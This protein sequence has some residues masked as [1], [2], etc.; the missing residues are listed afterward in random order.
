MPDS[1]DTLLA[2]LN[3]LRKSPITLSKTHS[4]DLPSTPQRTTDSDLTA[5]FRSLTPNSTIT[6]PLPDAEDTQHN[7]E[8]DR[9]IEELLQDLG[10]EEQWSVDRD[11][12]E[13]IRDLMAEAKSA[14]PA[15][16]NKEEENKDVDL[17]VGVARPEHDDE[18]EEQKEMDEDKRDEE[19]ADDYVQRV[20]AELTL[21]KK[22]GGPEEEE[23]EQDD[24]KRAN[25]DNELSLPSAPTELPSSPAPDQ[26]ANIDDA[27]SARFA[28]LS[29]PGVPSF[30]PAKKP[31]N[32]QKSVKSNLPKYT[33]EDMESWCCICNEDATVKCIGCDGDLYCQECWREGH[34]NGPGQERDFR[35]LDDCLGFAYHWHVDHFAIQCP[36]ASTLGISLFVGNDDSYGIIHLFLA[37]AENVLNQ[38]DLA[39]MDALLS[40]VTHSL[41]T[42]TFFLEDL[43]T[44][45]TAECS[46]DQIDGGRKVEGSSCRRDGRPRIQEFF[47]VRRTRDAKIEGKVLSS[48]DEATQ[49]RRSFANGRQVHD[50]SRR[51]NQGY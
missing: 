15:E 37:W 24:E 36:S 9:T 44:L 32:I 2:R 33:D 51:L 20:L 43:L 26:D 6:S 38:L 48:E 17:E 4:L 14:L 30:N 10:P 8:D 34:G 25:V 12:G 49:I 35:L 42:L 40:I 11:E 50:C 46:R 22:Y 1:D 23:E 13:R 21:E 27:L 39:R 41:T 16:D 5:R 3:A 47:E 19:E 45:L 29:L 18:D 7:N 31:V 28:S